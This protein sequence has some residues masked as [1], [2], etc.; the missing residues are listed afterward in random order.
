MYRKTHRIAFYT[1]LL[2]V[3]GVFFSVE[4]FF[5]FEGQLNA[6][7][8]LQYSSSTHNHPEFFKAMPLRSSATHKVRLNKRFHQEDIAPVSVFSIEA[9]IVRVIPRVMNFCGIVPLPSVTVVHHPL[10][11]PPVVA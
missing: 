9:P 11:G 8:I 2:A 7:E 3:Y 10:R 6:K 5:N 4:S 1:L